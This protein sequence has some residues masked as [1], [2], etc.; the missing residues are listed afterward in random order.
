MFGRAAIRLGIGPHSSSLYIFYCTAALFLPLW[1]IKMNIFCVRR[2]VVIATKS[3]HRLQIRS[4]V[5][6]YRGH[7]YHYPS[8]IRVRAV[9]WECGEGPT[10]RQTHTDTQ[11]AVINIHFARRHG[12]GSATTMNSI[13]TQNSI[14]FGDRAYWSDMT[15][16]VYRIKLSRSMTET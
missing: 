11:T 4:M 15:F 2:Y 1:L 13:F 6:T 5:H 7:P 8:Y 16:E 12:C 3:V 10:D 9:V 14:W